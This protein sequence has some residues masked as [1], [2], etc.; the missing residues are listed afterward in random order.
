MNIII[1]GFAVMTSYIAYG[2]CLNLLGPVLAA[3]G[4][5]SMGFMMVCISY[6]S[7][8]ITAI[9][10]P[11][12]VMRFYPPRTAIRAGP[13]GYAIFVLMGL[14]ACWIPATS[15]LAWVAYLCSYL[16]AAINGAANSMMACGHTAVLAANSPKHLVSKY[17]GWNMTI[18]AMNSI[19][20]GVVS[21]VLFSGGEFG[22][23]TPFFLFLVV[24]HGAAMA[25]TMLLKV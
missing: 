5:G 3:N 2:M 1:L 10:L 12:V 8:A 21:I 6:S 9:F 11:Q 4:Y 22:D 14:P 7:H 19:F 17:V 18:V 13:F 23:P 16:G 15:E 24:L 25:L 20:S